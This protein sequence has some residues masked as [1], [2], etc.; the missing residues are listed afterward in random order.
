MEA[1]LISQ[2]VE[3]DLCEDAIEMM[4][5]ELNTRLDAMRKELSVLKS[6]EQDAVDR[7]NSML[8]NIKSKLDYLNLTVTQFA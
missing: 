2:A 8:A 6:E 3:K 5:S 7:M 1:T 4:E